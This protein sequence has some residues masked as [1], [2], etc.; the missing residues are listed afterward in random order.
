MPLSQLRQAITKLILPTADLG[1]REQTVDPLLFP[2]DLPPILAVNAGQ[3]AA[4]PKLQT[5]GINGG[6][7]PG[8]ASEGATIATGNANVPITTPTLLVPANPNRIR[9]F[10]SATTGTGLLGLSGVSTANGFYL[11]ANTILSLATASAIYAV[12][13]SGTVAIYWL[14]ESA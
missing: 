3:S 2:D 5:L 9:I 12:S 6:I 4:G 10:F 11:P 7:M 1:L 13:T 8:V 14:E